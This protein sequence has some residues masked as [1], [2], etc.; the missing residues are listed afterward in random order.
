MDNNSPINPPTQISASHE[1]WGSDSSAFWNQLAADCEKQR[2]PDAV[3]PALLDELAS[4]LTP[5]TSQQVGWAK[6]SIGLYSENELWIIGDLHGDLLALRA[7]TTFAS[8]MSRKNNHQ[9]AVCFLGDFFDDGSFGH[10]VL[11]EALT[12]IVSADPPGFFVAGNHDLALCW[13]EAENRFTADV[14]P[15][16][17]A[18]WLNTQ[19]TDSHWRKFVQAVVVWFKSAPRALMF[20]DGTLVAHGG[21][22]HSDRLGLLCQEPDGFNHPDVLEDLVWLRAHDTAK[23]K[24]PNRTARGCQFGVDDFADF[25]IALNKLTGKAIS[26]VIRGHDHVTNRWFAPPH[27]D[28]RLL[29]INA[30]SW[31]QREPL[32]PFVRQPVIARYRSGESPELFQLEIPEQHVLHLYGE[33]RSAPCTTSAE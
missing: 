18:D 8:Y 26:R 23:R 11:Y 22:V 3:S 20:E 2:S 4:K 33:P 12:R 9:A 31:R 29:T 6:Q 17:F 32:G 16:D 25:L 15:H 7:L 14:A 27:Y 21:C 30:M 5:P 24:V 10:A 1:S 28:G 19:P 13:N